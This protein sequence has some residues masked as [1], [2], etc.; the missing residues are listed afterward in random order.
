MADKQTTCIY[1]GTTVNLSRGEGDHVIPAALGRF[2]DEFHFRRICPACNTLIG[3]CEEQLLRCAPEAFVRR[4]VQPTVERNRRG[5]SWVGA[6]GIPPPKFTINHGDHLELVHGSIDDPRNVRPK[7]QLVIVDKEKGEHCIPLFPDMT[8]AHLRAKIGA[9]GLSPSNK[10]HLHADEAVY[11]KYV[12]MLKEIWP[13][14]PIEEREGCEAGIHGVPGRTFFAIHAD[15]WRAIAKIGFHYYLLNTRR[16]MRGDEAE[17]ADIRRFIIDGGDL[18]P[19]FTN[20]AARF[21]LPFREL[22]DGD[23]ILP[24]EWGHVLAA[25]ESCQTAVAMVSLFMGPER[26]APTYHIN[27]GRFPTPL[28]V[29]DARCSHAYL[30]YAERNQNKYAGRVVMMPI[31]QLN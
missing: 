26:L 14:S 7:D 13:D 18:E 23:A 1:C 21:A 31:T 4:M 22:P 11:P 27:I 24:S 6:N 2:E 15:Y 5:T 29:P 25:D 3:K 8:V 30:Y 12:A 20:P 16:G 28:I 19:F 9:L 10:F 17:F